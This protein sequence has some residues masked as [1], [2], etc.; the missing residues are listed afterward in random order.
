MSDPICYCG[1]VMRLGAERENQGM[2]GYC[3]NWTLRCPRCGIWKYYAAD[4]FYGRDYIATREEVV[5]T[6]NQ[7][8]T[9]M[10]R[11][12]EDNNA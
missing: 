8:V 6:W 3:T 4:G 2:D 5:D 12:R 9:E 11:N 1:E 10:M 7:T